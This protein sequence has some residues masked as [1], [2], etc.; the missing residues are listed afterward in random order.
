VETAAAKAYQFALNDLS[1]I[2]QLANRE[3]ATGAIARAAQWPSLSQMAAGELFS[4]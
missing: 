3:F 4:P 2:R 1:M